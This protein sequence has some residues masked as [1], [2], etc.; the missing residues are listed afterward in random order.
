[1][2]AVL[3]K[4]QIPTTDLKD[5]IQRAEK[6]STF[7]EVI[8]LSC[9]MQLKCVNNT[10][11]VTTTNNVYYIS[12]KLNLTEKYGSTNPITIP[13]FELVVETKLFSSL[14]SKLSTDMTTLTIDDNTVTIE[15]NG[16]YSLPISSDT[17]GSKISFPIPQVDISTSST[18]HLN[19]NEVRSILNINK[20]CKADSKDIPSLFN[21]YFDQECALTTNQYKG[22]QNPI[23]LSDKPICLSP[24]VMDLVP[25]VTDEKY[26]VDI[27]QDSDYIIFSS[28]CG[29]LIG[30]KESAVDLQQFPV[31]GLKGAVNFSFSQEVDLNRSDLLSAIERICL[32]VQPYT[33]NKI[34]ATFDKEGLTLQDAQGAS[35]EFLPYI[36]PLVQDFAQVSLS[37]DGIYLKDQLSACTSETLKVKVHSERGLVISYNNITLALGV[38]YEDTTSVK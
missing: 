20:S 33:H 34:I 16:K 12:S 4:V 7:V 17:D 19:I 28:P 38:L 15:A 5:L 14:I 3:T 35:S 37:L 13:D 8:P 22:C 26:G 32:F 30:I 31:E 27:A 23:I 29:E 24:T 11:S 2:T 9:L 21:Y 36:T 1:M 6:G 18:K 10:L 25:Y